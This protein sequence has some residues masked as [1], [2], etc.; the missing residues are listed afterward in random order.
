MLGTLPSL[1]EVS[2]VL[3]FVCVPDLAVPQ[4]PLSLALS[5]SLCNNYY[6]II[7]NHFGSWCNQHGLLKGLVDRDRL[8][9][10]RQRRLN[11]S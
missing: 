5:G 1:C 8:V 9:S 3:L 2:T 10:I 4:L 11:L 6:R 7:E